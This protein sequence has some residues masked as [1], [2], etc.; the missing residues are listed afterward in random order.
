MRTLWRSHGWKVYAALALGAL[1]CSVLFARFLLGTSFATHDDEGYFLLAMRRYW[2]RGDLAGEPWKFEHYGP[3]YYLV[4]SLFMGKAVTHDAGRWATLCCW[5]G[6]ASLSGWFMWCATRVPLLAASAVLASVSV[7]S[8]LGHEPGHPQQEVA[9]LL[10]LACAACVHPGLRARWVLGAVG[11]AL[12]LTKINVGAFYLAALLHAAAC[13]WMRGKCRDIAITVSLMYAVAAAPVLAAGHLA[14]GASGFALV[15][16]LCAAVTF[17]YGLRARHDGAWDSP[18]IAAV[19]R[20][21]GMA[22]IATLIV[23]MFETQSI[24]RIGELWEGLVLQPA[25]NPAGGLFL[26]FRLGWVECAATFVVLATVWCVDRYAREFM[27]W[28]RAGAGL[29]GIFLLVRTDLTW[30]MPLVPLGVLPLTRRAWSNSE[31]F[32]RIFVADLAVTEFLQTYPVAGGQAGIA[33][34]PVMLWSFLCLWDGLEEVG[35]RRWARPVAALITV[36]VTAG[37]WRSGLRQFGYPYAPS[38]LPGSSRLHLEPGQADTYRFLS[39][40]IRQNCNLLYTLPRLHSFNFW[41][42]VD[43]PAYSASPLSLQLYTVARQET[44]LNQLRKDASSC[45]V[46][47]RAILDFWQAPQGFVDQSPLVQYVIREMPVMVSRDGYE[48]RVNPARRQP[49]R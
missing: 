47:N 49:W 42:S 33:A 45:A 12:V 10:A 29:A 5:L 25:R 17:A 23:S 4:Q 40:S 13:V 41:S 21:F 7:L 20:G 38:R 24:Y 35:R 44:V 18:H 19:A 46:Y 43:A 31:W 30:V 1:V 39:N 34:L 3:F 22:A 27:G 16:S 37:M 6:A 26:G 8:V 28:V 15:A 14:D 32:T 48:I 36:V 11:A 2:F 9:V